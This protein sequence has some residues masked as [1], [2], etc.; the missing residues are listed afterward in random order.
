MRS[1]HLTALSLTLLTTGLAAP[2][3]MAPAHAVAPD[4]PVARQVAFTGENS[5][6]GSALSLSSCDVNGDQISDTVVGDQNWNRPPHDKVGAA[7]VI[8][9]SNTAVGGDVTDPASANAVRLDG[10]PKTVT[11]GTWAGFSV[12]CLGDVNGDGLDDVAVGY[13]SRFQQEAAVVFGARDFGPVDLSELGERGFRITDPGAADTTLFDRS[14]DNFGYSVGS[15]GDVDGDGLDDIAVSDLLADYNGNNAGRVWVVKGKRGSADVNVQTDTD[16]VLMTV[17]GAAASARLAGA[18]AAGDANGDGKD[19]LLVGSYT[20][21]PWGADAP[22]AGAASL[23]HGGT[24]ASV[25]LGT[26]EAPGFDVFGPRRGRDRL[27]MSVAPVGDV[28][29]D[30]LADFVAGG[31]GVN[32]S[33]ARHG[34]AAVVLGSASA[35]VVMVDPA[36]STSVYECADGSLTE[37]CAGSEKVARGHWI[38]GATDGS[39]AGFAVAGIPDVNGDGTPDLLVGAYNEDSRGAAYLLKLDGARTAPLELSTLTPEQGERFVPEIGTGRYGRTLA[40]VGDFDGNGEQDFFFGGAGTTLAMVLRGDA[41][42]EVAAVA[43]Q[44]VRAGDTSALEVDV[45]TKLAQFADDVAG[46]VAL[47]VDGRAVDGAVTVSEGRAEIEVPALSH[48]AHELKVAFVPASGAGLK[49]SETTIAFETALREGKGRLSLDSRSVSAGDTVEAVLSTSQPLTGEVEFLLDGTPLGR[50]RVQDGE[51]AFTLEAL[52]AGQHAVTARYLGD[53]IHAAFSTAA[54]TVRVAKIDAEPGALTLSSRAL[55]HGTGGVL[56][57][58]TVPGGQG[59]RVTFYLD[60]RAIGSSIADASGTASLQIA[61]PAV[62]EH[63]VSARFGGNATLLAG[64]PG[65]EATFVVSRAKVAKVA[66]SGKKFRKGTAPKVTVKLGKLDNGAYPVGKV[67]VAS[68]G[69]K[70][71]AKVTAK[72]KGKVVL[73]LKKAT[74]AVKVRATFTPTDARNVAKAT[75][76]KVTVKVRR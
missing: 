73:T 55:V 31:D 5:T 32:T 20:G 57:R 69:K 45:T 59:G 9:G 42:T 18:T 7:Y 6:F 65:D 16:Q 27:G 19:D 8:F 76:A 40:S 67:T 15:A 54:T 50:A 22:V 37:D 34:G 25:V 71:S 36:S 72:S 30:G 1:R 38:N 61:S 11:A 66:V 3:V 52:T 44:G 13:G 12:S 48:G 14:S 21:T 60:G 64:V 26:P 10:P 28:N 47:T 17:D 49:S 2:A 68:G 46:T 39:K 51:A 74:R 43:E 58:V 41:N 70:Y 63:Q 23:V 75:S 62:G 29:G 4:A 56:A 53:E 33:G 35:N 24:S